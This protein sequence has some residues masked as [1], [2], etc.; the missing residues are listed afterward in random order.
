MMF[1]N[2][3]KAPHGSKTWYFDDIYTTKSIDTSNSYKQF[4][5]TF[6]SLSDDVVS[7]KV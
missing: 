3:T 5:K 7:Q 4:N 2:I 6:K 1:K